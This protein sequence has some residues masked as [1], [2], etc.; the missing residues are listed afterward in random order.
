[1]RWQDGHWPGKAEEAC[2]HTK[3]Q[4][5]HSEQ[6]L[7]VAMLGN[8]PAPYRILLSSLNIHDLL[9][10]RRDVIWVICSSYFAPRPLMV[11]RGHGGAQFPPFPSTTNEVGQNPVR[12]TKSVEEPCPIP[13]CTSHGNEP[14]LDGVINKRGQVL[15]SVRIASP[16]G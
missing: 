3:V 11:D 8:W 15:G 1:M 13:F 4:R 7:H 9:V 14:C 16:R 6:C 10:E 5:L 2:G 12:N